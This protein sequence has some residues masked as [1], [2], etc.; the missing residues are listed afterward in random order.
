[1]YGI[2]PLN[3]IGIQ[4]CFVVLT[5]LAHECRFYKSYITAFVALPINLGKKNQFKW[6]C[7]ELQ[8]VSSA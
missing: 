8:V 2:P 6:S 7:Q 5:S 4:L 1:M 3:L